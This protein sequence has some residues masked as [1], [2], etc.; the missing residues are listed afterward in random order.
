MEWLS[1]EPEYH[2]QWITRVKSLA[3]LANRL[4][5]KRRTC[6]AKTQF[7]GDQV[8]TRKLEDKGKAALVVRAAFVFNSGLFHDRSGRSVLHPHSS[9]IQP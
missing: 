2:E 7:N 6:S 8:A 9:L 5:Y 1:E 3:G 4:L